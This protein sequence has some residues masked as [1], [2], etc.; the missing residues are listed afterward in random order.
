MQNP[1]NASFTRAGVGQRR[2]LSLRLPSQHARC[3]PALALAG[4]PTLAFPTQ[5]FALPLLHTA[6]MTSPSI[7]VVVVLSPS[8]MRLRDGAKDALAL[9]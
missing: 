5:S 1:K 4:Q 9:A 8:M 7:V 2:V 6:P 3:A